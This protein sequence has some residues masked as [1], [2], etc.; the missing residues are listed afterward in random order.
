[1]LVLAVTLLAS[2]GTKYLKKVNFGDFWREGVL[3]GKTKQ[4]VNIMNLFGYHICLVYQILCA[5]TLLNCRSPKVKAAT[6][7]KIK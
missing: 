2:V 1:M 7:Q 3:M 5:K 4:N 6:N